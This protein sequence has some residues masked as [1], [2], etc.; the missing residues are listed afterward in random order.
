MNFRSFD[1]WDYVTCHAYGKNESMS[2]FLKYFEWMCRYYDRDNTTQLIEVGR[3]SKDILDKST[4]EIIENGGFDLHKFGFPI[5]DSADGFI[6]NRP[7]YIHRVYS[8]DGKEIVYYQ[9]FTYLHDI[10]KYDMYKMIREAIRSY[11]Y[12][13]P[14]V[15]DSL[16]KLMMPAKMLHVDDVITNASTREEHEAFYFNRRSLKAILYYEHLLKPEFR[17]FNTMNECTSTTYRK[18][19]KPGH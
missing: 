2:E 13:P 1:D 4:K 17:G 15:I 7:G 12:R 10:W 5:K 6:H 16:Y 8:A 18:N 14:V 3:H 9:E 19:R 11:I